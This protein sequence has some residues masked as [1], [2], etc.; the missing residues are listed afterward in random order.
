[1]PACNIT[2]SDGG[3]RIEH[4]TF[5]ENIIGLRIK[6]SANISIQQSAF[7]S[8]VLKSNGAIPIGL[9]IIESLN[10]IVEDNNIFRDSEYGILLEG[11]FPLSSGVQ[12]GKLGLRNNTFQKNLYSIYA[13]GNTHPIGVIENNL[14]DNTS[15]TNWDGLFGTFLLGDNDIDFNNNTLN[16]V[17]AGLVSLSTG[18]HFNS[19]NCN[20]Y[21][22]S[23]AQSNYFI[24]DNRNTIILNNNF[25]SPGSNR[26][27]A[28]I[29]Q[30]RIKN[31]QGSVNASSNNCF[32]KGDVKEFDR[33]VDSDDFNYFYRSD[34]SDDDCMYPQNSNI[35]SWVSTLTG[36][37]CGTDGIGINLTGNDDPNYNDFFAYSPLVNNDNEFL[38]KSCILEDITTYINQVISENGDNPLTN[39][40]ENHGYNYTGE[41]EGLL[42]DLLNSV[43]TVSI[44]NSDFGFAEQVLNNLQ[45]WEWQVKLFGIYMKSKQFNKASILL[46]NMEEREQFQTDFIAVQSINLQRL[47]N[48][49]ITFEL[50][51]AQKEILESIVASHNR[52]SGYAWSLYHI[53][54]GEKL[55]IDLPIVESR[56]HLEENA[57]N[58][59]SSLR[60]FPNPSHTVINISSETTNVEKV[61][62]MSLN[63]EIIKV[64]SDL[65]IHGM[66][67]V[68]DI[69]KGLYLLEILMSDNS[70]NF[71]RVFIIN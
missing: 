30:A 38:C 62:L 65:K 47:N 26:D 13:S 51:N 25:D 61:T 34:G 39:Y 66:L 27:V 50:S 45:K 1:M 60:V 64:K 70:V 54:T 28:L 16:N 22:D 55:I 5:F 33:S 2:N 18:A 23:W 69:P 32:T 46:T 53:L 10:I 49:G 24:G 56:S 11:T 4:S 41:G 6:E 36:S 15:G 3:I 63:G 43:L 14:F 42:D 12:V 71:E 8:P 20:E 52:S 44:E 59:K 19:N 68:H 37:Y 29:D 67:N 40:I 17:Q 35:S 31:S 21:K 9:E 58:K 48:Q 57:E 7:F